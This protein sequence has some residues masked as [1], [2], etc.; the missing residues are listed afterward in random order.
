MEEEVHGATGCGAQGLGRTGLGSVASR[1]PCPGVWWPW[2]SFW[3]GEQAGVSSY[4]ASALT[5]L[6]Q[7]VPRLSA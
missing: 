2:D 6:A 7:W 5:W 4:R 1:R 3:D